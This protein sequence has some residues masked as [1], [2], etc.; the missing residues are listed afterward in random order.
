MAIASQ[1]YDLAEYRDLRLAVDGCIKSWL[2]N[3]TV[4]RRVAM[5]NSVVAV[6]RKYRRREMQF[7]TYTVRLETFDGRTV[8][9]IRA[10]RVL[11]GCP[12]CNRKHALLYIRTQRQDL[13][14]PR[15][16]NTLACVECAEIFARWEPNEW[17]D[18]NDMA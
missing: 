12:R 16:L 15:D 14:G 7:G 10:R 6:M 3:P 4:S 13:F 5:E 9:I 8:P 1:V 17:S 2:K 11:R 18:D